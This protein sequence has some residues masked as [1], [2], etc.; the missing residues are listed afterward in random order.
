MF[1]PLFCP[2]NDPVN[3]VRECLSQSHQVAFMAE[4]GFCLFAYNDIH[5]VTKL[6]T[7]FKWSSG[8][9]TKPKD[10]I[11]ITNVRI[12]SDSFWNNTR[13][14]Q[15]WHSSYLYCLYCYFCGKW[16][17]AFYNIVILLLLGNFLL[18]ILG[19]NYIESCLFSNDIHARYTQ[20]SSLPLHPANSPVS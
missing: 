6:I 7:H 2:H 1:G 16:I 11:G 9:W 13:L 14:F 5:P 3:Q 17:I 18:E 15:H 20:L 12:F 4:Q 8:S 10:R 19:I